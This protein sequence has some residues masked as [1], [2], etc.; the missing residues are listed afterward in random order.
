MAESNAEVEDDRE[1]HDLTSSRTL[2]TAEDCHRKVHFIQR[3]T[4]KMISVEAV[5]AHVREEEE[6][7]EEGLRIRL[8]ILSE[9]LFRLQR[10]HIAC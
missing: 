9:S 8:L 1:K 5:E 4:D 3:K 6:E 7:E 10:P 2:A